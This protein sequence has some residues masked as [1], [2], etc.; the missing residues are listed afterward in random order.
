[1][2]AHHMGLCKI[3]PPKTWCPR[4]R[5]YED[6]SN[7]VIERPIIQL[8]SG[9]AGVYFQ[10]RGLGIHLIE[11]SQDVRSQKNL[12]FEK[13]AKL[14][15]S[16]KAQRPRFRNISELE[17]QYWS[18]IKN[19]QPLYGANV[20]GTLTDPTEPAFNIPN[21]ESALSLVLA[22]ENVQINGVNTPYLYFGMWATTFAWHVEDIDLYSINYLH[23][24]SPKLWYVI[25]PAFARRFE[26]F[27]REHF[28]PEF[29]G[30]RSFLR[31]KS[32]LIHPDVLA[33][34]GIPTRKILQYEGEIMCTFPYGYHAGFNTGLNC[35][36]STNFALPR[37]VEYGKKATICKC[38][39]DTV[40][41]N[42]TPFVRKYQPE[43]FEAWC[44]GQDTAPHP[45]ELYCHFRWGDTQWDRGDYQKQQQPLDFGILE[46]VEDDLSESSSDALRMA[47]LPRYL[48]R[49]PIFQ[50]LWC[51]AE[52]RLDAEVYFNELMGAAEPFCSICSFF[53]PP[54][55]VRKA[56]QGA[57]YG[58]PLPDF[59]EPYLSEVAF[60]RVP[61]DFPRINLEENPASRVLR[62]ASCHVVVHARC[63]GL[64]DLE[65]CYNRA[66]LESWICDACSS[67]AS[68]GRPVAHLSSSYQSTLFE[69]VKL[70]TASLPP[71]R[72][73]LCPIRG[74]ALKQLENSS[75]D[76]QSF[77]V[78]LAC[79]IAVGK[80]CRFVDVVR[81]RPLLLRRSELQSNPPSHLPSSA[82]NF[83]SWDSCRST[84]AFLRT[85]SPPSGGRPALQTSVRQLYRDA[86]VWEP[87]KRR[88]SVGTTASTSRERCELC[89]L[90]AP[91]GPANLPL[92]ACW[93][94]NCPG[95]VHL[96][97]A[98]LSGYLVA[99]GRYP[100]C[101]Y[102]AC[103]R[104]PAEYRE[105]LLIILQS[106][107]VTRNYYFQ[108]E[109]NDNEVPLEPGDSVYAL[110]SATGHYY[111]ARA[112]ELL[113]PSV[114]KVA[115]FDGTFS[116][117]T[118]IDCILV[119][120][121]NGDAKRLRRD[122]IFRVN[123]QIP[124]HIRKLIVSFFYLI[125][126]RRTV[127]V[128][129]ELARYKV[130]IAALSETR[131]SEQGQ[132]EEVGAGY[133]FFWSGRPKAE[134]R[135]VGVAFAIRNDTVGRLPCL[136]QGINDRKFATIISALRSLNN[137]LLCGEGQTLRGPACLAGD[138]AE[139]GQ[140]YCLW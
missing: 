48:H 38:W 36:E 122:K 123:Q 67:H 24:G 43:L 58:Q 11:R 23:F 108:H 107:V 94:E 115:F 21:L 72:C 2:G 111:P 134:Q 131:F 119:R 98:Q 102:V 4:R 25:P 7:F 95:R 89:C 32:V 45:L 125:A 96:T 140:V 71:Q 42:M 57:D 136:P 60:I 84:P 26:A 49:K 14:S 85:G 70:L 44:R 56:L 105:N 27:A 50:A 19:L 93:H 129:R 112:E 101:L 40:R 54:T 62:C 77:W 81:R 63:Y 30:C 52:E 59:S 8:T 138:C 73:C 46:P 97:C 82:S 127:L 135:D 16:A 133:T 1:M 130:D 128:A 80:G 64:P 66:D 137:E 104:H 53:W 39:D 92:V 121:L 35:A 13:F 28:K 34:A 5:G 106:I 99:T 55:V 3:I 33:E 90:P 74:G 86:Y 41:L 6:L 87:L 37:W 22:E 75:Q 114:C 9:T 10:V 61:A 91:G 120:F 124:T 31:H 51:G 47:V 69:F 88:S 65:T 29:L 117:D 17:S 126:E 15:K 79:A 110:D 113:V 132:L 139:G 83:H 76:G 116:R 118:P 68:R 78:H 103:R 12:T 100:H 109:Q 18:S 20:S